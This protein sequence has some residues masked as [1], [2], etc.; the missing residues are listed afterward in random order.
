MINQQRDVQLYNKETSGPHSPLNPNSCRVCVCCALLGQHHLSNPDLPSVKLHSWLK[1]NVNF[2]MEPSWRYCDWAVHVNIHL[3]DCAVNMA[4]LTRLVLSSKGVGWY[5][6]FFFFTPQRLLFH[7]SGVNPLTY[8]ETTGGYLW[9][10]AAHMTC[11]WIS[12]QTIWFTACNNSNKKEDWSGHDGCVL[13]CRETANIPLIALGLKETKEINFS[14]PFKVR[15]YSPIA[16]LLGEKMCVNS[17][18]VHKVFS[19]EDFKTEVS[20]QEGLGSYCLPYHAMFSVYSGAW[21]AYKKIPKTGS[22]AI[23]SGELTWWWVTA[24]KHSRKYPDGSFIAFRWFIGTHCRLSLN[25]LWA[26]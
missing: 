22:M 4:T 14:T 1:W 12:Q 10:R 19:Y 16:L 25:S 9:A 13:C 18:Y 3:S 11:L 24:K 26:G 2:L 17:F 23:T 7:Y 5:L 15:L 8:R 6:F 20:S 21:S